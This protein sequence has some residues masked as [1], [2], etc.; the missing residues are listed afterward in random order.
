[1]T[2]KIEGRDFTWALRKKPSTFVRDYRVFLHESLQLPG[3]IL[4]GS[5]VPLGLDLR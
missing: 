2:A 3:N 4:H 1:M 5:Y